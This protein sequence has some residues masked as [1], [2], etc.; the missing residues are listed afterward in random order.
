[1]VNTLKVWWNLCL[2]GSELF[3]QQEGELLHIRQVDRCICTLKKQ[4]GTLFDCIAW[5]NQESLPLQCIYKI[6]SRLEYREKGEH[7]MASHGPP[8]K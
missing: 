1:M 6:I 4:A 5:F 3:L 2:Y 7:K 8:Y